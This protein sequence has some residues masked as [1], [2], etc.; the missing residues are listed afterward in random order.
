MAELRIRNGSPVPC[1]A[2]LFD[3]DG[4]LLDML[5][6]WG[7][8]AEE[9]LDGLEH[10]LNH[11]GVGWIGLRDSVLGTVRGAEGR[12]AAYDPAGPLPMA[13]EEQAY[14]LLAWQLYAAAGMPWN[15]ALTE[16]M[17]I[18]GRAS[19][20]VRRRRL[21]YPVPGLLP[22]LESCRAASI[23]LGVV[24]SDGSAATAEHL[25]WLGVADR[26]AAVVTRDRV[27]LGKP[28]PEMALMAL[29]ELGVSADETVLIG[30]SNADMQMGRH[31]GLRCCIGLSPSGERGP[32]LDA[33]V[34]VKDYTE[35]DLQ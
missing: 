22:F 13:T 35:L 17:A 12:I 29:R 20:G 30:D 24:T 6:M 21:A 33:D 9:V 25:D 32:L 8:W 14:G 7:A 11:E 1:R 31:A 4:T 18:C 34:I 3:K 10:R 26:F 28:D 5:R 15:E 19:E 16:V 2:V 27:R 23:P